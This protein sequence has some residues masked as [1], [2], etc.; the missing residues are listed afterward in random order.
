MIDLKFIR[1]NS[2]KVA[3]GAN[4]KNIE[5]DIAKISRLDEN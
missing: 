1:E 4:S 3:T 5:I 2:E